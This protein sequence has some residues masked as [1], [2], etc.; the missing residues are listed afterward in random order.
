VSH[1]G[2]A[3]WR[4]AGETGARHP[5]LDILLCEN[6]VRGQKAAWKP[7]L[8]TTIDRILVRGKKHKATRDGQRGTKGEHEVSRCDGAMDHGFE[9]MNR[10]NNRGPCSPSNAKCQLHLP[11][12]AFFI[13]P[14]SSILRAS[15]P[16]SHQ[17]EVLTPPSAKNL[18]PVTRFS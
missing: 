10:D 14:R 18:K 9:L 4:A 16:S 17:S 7:Q 6:Y 11:Y 15:C 13:R 3:Q 8:I 2:A 1:R 12:L 5:S